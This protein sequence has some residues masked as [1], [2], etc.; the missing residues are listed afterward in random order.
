MIMDRVSGNGMGRQSG[1]RNL[2]IIMEINYCDVNSIV[3]VERQD[4]GVVNR[5]NKVC[6]ELIDKF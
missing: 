4:R 5:D 3:I 1:S 2:M 6:K